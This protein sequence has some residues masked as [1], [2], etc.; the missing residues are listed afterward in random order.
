MNVAIDRNACAGHGL[1][2]VYAPN[3]FTDDDQGYAQV[4]GCRVVAAA[5]EEA[6]RTAIANC[7]ERAIVAE[8]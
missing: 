6:T 3:I 5:D 7:P 2:Y 1:C 4:V 8:T